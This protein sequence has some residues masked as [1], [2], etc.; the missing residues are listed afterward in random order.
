[1]TECRLFGRMFAQWML[2]AWIGSLLRSER[3]LG[4]RWGFEESNPP[5]LPRSSQLSCCAAESCEEALL[6][7]RLIRN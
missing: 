6:F 4:K 1:M 7:T 3:V 2:G 5:P